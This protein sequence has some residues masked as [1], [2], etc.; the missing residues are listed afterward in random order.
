MLQILKSIFFLFLF[1]A[2]YFST[3]A[4]GHFS[5]D[6]VRYLEDITQEL[7]V[8]TAVK[9]GENTTIGG[10]VK[11]LLMDVYEP[12][13]D[14]VEK[15]PVIV[16]AF[17]GGFVNGNRENMAWLCEIFARKGYVATTIDYR[18]VDA[19]IVDTT[20]LAD[21]VM[22]AMSDMKAAIRFLREDAATTNQFRIDSDLVFAGGISAGA[23]TAV[24]AA[25]LDE[26]DE[27]PAYIQE[28]IDSNGG[29]EGN[30]SNNFDYSSSIQG[31][32]N[33][34]GALKEA[35]WMDADE[36]PIF[37]AHDDMDPIV[38]YG[39]EFFNTGFPSLVIHLEGSGS[40]AA[41]ADNIG[42]TNDLLTV[43]NSEGH[44]SFFTSN[45]ATYR[46]DVLERSV[47]LLYNIVCDAMLSDTK[48]AEKLAAAIHLYP[49]PASS[50]LNIQLDEIP[51]SFD[52]LVYDIMGKLVAQQQNL[53]THSI[54]LVRQ[55]LAAG[56]YSIHLRFT[57]EYS[58]IIQKKVVFY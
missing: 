36:A 32:L 25:Y 22:R 17:G 5:C 35:T 42:L 39:N 46:V 45:A 47:I 41:I 26:G 7:E 11:E 43:T 2:F 55:D 40:M 37:S 10:N 49:N 29:L 6:D 57:D 30:S 31:V 16:F 20:L 52:V 53:N 9:F 18:L 54:S 44:V 58:T 51:A 1:L 28:F 24:H 38:P 33:Y 27:V 23:I 8:T 13:N 14:E 19:F 3:I 21:V 48:E 56:L 50:H 12:A 34:S 4:Q 15:R